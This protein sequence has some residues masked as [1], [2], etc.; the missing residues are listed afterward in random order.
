MVS[1]CIPTYNG[2]DYLHEAIQSALFQTYRD[3]ELIIVDDRSTDHTVEIAEQLT[4]GLP[5]VRLSQ[6][7]VRQGLGGNWNKCI[8]M[9][10][11]E[12]IKFLFQDDLLAP[13]CIEKLH[14][15][16]VRTNHLLAICGRQFDFEDNIPESYREKFLQYVQT[17]SLSNRFPHCDSV[18]DAK[19]FAAHVREY[20]TYNCVGEPTA[21]LFHRSTV[22]AFGYFNPDLSQIIDW[23]Y[24][25]RVAVNRGLC[26]TPENLATFRIHDKGMSA[27][28]WSD[29][30]RILMDKIDELIVYH[31]QYYNTHYSALYQQNDFIRKRN[32]TLNRFMD[33]YATIQTLLHQYPVDGIRMMRIE[34]YRPAS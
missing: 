8:E 27:A 13:D 6:N 2:A 14:Q 17:N 7:A 34:K 19:T 20:P 33:E 10:T 30:S 5:N 18:I 15:L 29:G 25:M 12:W 11:G 32:I 28:N 4:Q 23:E 16:A 21:V 26:F 24:W 9:A 31:E 22:P 1:V 3:I